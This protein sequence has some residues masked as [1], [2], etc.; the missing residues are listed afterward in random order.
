MKDTRVDGLGTVSE[1]S[2]AFKSAASTTTQSTPQS[3]AATPQNNGAP[4]LRTQDAMRPPA[5]LPLDGKSATV[6]IQDTAAMHVVID[7]YTPHDIPSHAS[8][9][10]LLTP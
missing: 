9:L 8:T 7:S 6:R 4:S 3:I 5:V 2:D 1:R 10:F